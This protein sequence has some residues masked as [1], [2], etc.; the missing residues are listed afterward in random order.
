MF[1]TKVSQAELS[2]DFTIAEKKLHMAVSVCK[3]DPGKK[4]SK[5][6]GEPK[7]PKEQTE[8]KKPKMAQQVTTTES[9]QQ[10]TNIPDTQADVEAKEQLLSNDDDNS[11][12]DPFARV[13]RDTEY[14]RPK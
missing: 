11:L 9:A 1:D 3:H 2:W 6:K 4:P 12:Q 10:A 14:L 13:E 7:D 8:Q 5:R